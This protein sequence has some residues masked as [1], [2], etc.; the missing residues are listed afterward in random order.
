[1]WEERRRGEGSEKRRGGEGRGEDGVTVCEG[2]G[3][4]RGDVEG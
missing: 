4:G 2:R 3:V 1:M